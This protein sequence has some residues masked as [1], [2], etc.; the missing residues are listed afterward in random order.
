MTD[1]TSLVYGSVDPKT[2][3]AAWTVGDSKTPI[4][5]AGIANL[6]KN[7]TTMMVHYGKEGSQQYTLFRIER[8][9]EEDKP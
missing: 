2:Q 8:P 5:E 6:T 4:Y 1:S 9:A 7:E 3:R